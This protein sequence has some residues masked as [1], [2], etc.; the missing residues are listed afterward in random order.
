[1][2]TLAEIRSTTYHNSDAAKE[3]YYSSEAYNESY[4]LGKASLPDSL[5][6]TSGLY[7]S[8]ESIPPEGLGRFINGYHPVTN[9]FLFNVKNKEEKQ[10]TPKQKEKI[11]DYIQTHWNGFEPDLRDAVL[12]SKKDLEKKRDITDDDFIMELTDNQKKEIEKKYFKKTEKKYG[13]DAC[14]SAPRDFTMLAFFDRSDQEEYKKIYN[15]AVK[16]TSFKIEQLIYNRKQISSNEVNLI[17]EHFQTIW[18]GKYETYKDARKQAY[19]NYLNGVAVDKTKNKTPITSNIREKIRGYAKKLQAPVKCLFMAYNHETSRPVDGQRP[20]PN[21][22]TH[23][24]IMNKALDENG[25]WV[26]IE[27]LDVYRQQ[28]AI[29]A[30]FRSQLAKGLREKLG[31]EIEPIKEL[32]ENENDKKVDHIDS[33]KV[34]GI[35]DEQRLMF[36]KRTAQINKV[37]GED[38]TY[39]TKKKISLSYRDKKQEWKRE[40]LL[41][42]WREDAEK[43]G[44]NQN[45]I[46]SIKTQKDNR[47]NYIK[48]EKY[49]A[50]SAKN[51]GVVDI[52]KLKAKFIENEQYTGMDGEKMFNKIFNDEFLIKTKKPHEFKLNITGRQAIQSQKELLG[53][54]SL[55]ETKNQNLVNNMLNKPS[56]ILIDDVVNKAVENTAFKSIIIDYSSLD[57][58]KM[59]VGNLQKMLTDPDVSEAEKAKIKIQIDELGFKIIEEEKKLKNQNNQDNTI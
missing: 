24:L 55:P 7:E 57:S 10:Y 36:S 59:E 23:L 4:F 29:G 50:Y 13:N 41:K 46:E 3:N 38:S 12:K 11:F 26:S 52:Y 53:F 6:V 5:K 9:T 35:T 34:K 47:K 17:V 16:K 58:M 48:T 32:F 18:D 43:V 33:F 44:I 22:H 30:Y 56:I 8:L 2:L 49:I 31:F 40:D 37:A 25:K 21:L 15:E 45:F 19:D 54:L 14:L 27:V 39:L 20:D 42:V 51:K 1:M 28:K